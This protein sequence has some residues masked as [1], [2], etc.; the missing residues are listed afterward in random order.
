MST[1]DRL[2]LA[3]AQKSTFFVMKLQTKG[4]MWSRTCRCCYQFYTS[5]DA[6]HKLLGKRLV[7]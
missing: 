5:K 3:S 6:L 2:L 1:A 7:W 4:S